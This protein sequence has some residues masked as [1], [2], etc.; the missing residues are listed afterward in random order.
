[1]LARQENTKSKDEKINNIKKGVQYA[2]EAVNLDAKDGLSWAVLGNAHLSAFFGIQ[3][4]PKTLHE[5]LKAYSQ[6][7]SCN[8]Y[9]NL[10]L[11]KFHRN[12]RKQT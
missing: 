10:C 5:C 8:S 1:M 4:N 2:K 11:Q 6:A 9:L 3:Q 7:V 12:S